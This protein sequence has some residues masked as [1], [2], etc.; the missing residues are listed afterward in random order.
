MKS[1]F[2][3]VN[4][5]RVTGRIRIAGYTSG[6]ASIKPSQI[7]HLRSFQDGWFLNHQWAKKDHEN[8]SG[9]VLLPATGTNDKTSDNLITVYTNLDTLEKIVDLAEAGYSFDLTPYTGKS[10]KKLDR[11]EDLFKPENKRPVTMCKVPKGLQ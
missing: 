7:H 8:A 9:I 10:A 5:P 3:R 1:Q 11:L 2:T 6:I 4:A